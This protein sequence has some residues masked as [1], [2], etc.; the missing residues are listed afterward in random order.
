MQV[1]D[2]PRPALR[3]LAER[4]HAIYGVELSEDELMDSP[5]IF[6]GSVGQLERNCVE[7]RD[8]FGISYVMVSDG[9][10]E[11]APVVE[12]VAGR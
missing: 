2:E 10:E 4:L 11:F 12:H 6:I 5:C 7:L 8:R 9:M 1:T 3:A